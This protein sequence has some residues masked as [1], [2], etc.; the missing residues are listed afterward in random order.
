MKLLRKTVLASVVV[1]YALSLSA[2]VAAEKSIEN[3]PIIDQRIEGPDATLLAGWMKG[4][5]LKKES[6]TAIP[7][8]TDITGHPRIALES[9]MIY[10]LE[11]IAC[12]NSECAPLTKDK[13]SAKKAADLFK[14]LGVEQTKGKSVK[15]PYFYVKELTCGV[16]DEKKTP[17]AC[18]VTAHFTAKKKK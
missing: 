16:E 18:Y 13:K 11:A 10:R 6:I 2:V 8:N 1:F 15:K 17:I 12:S 14:K 9:P 4:A 7:D 3:K 5:G